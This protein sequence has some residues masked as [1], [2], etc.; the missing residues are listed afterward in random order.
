[1]DASEVVRFLV[2]KH[3]LDLRDESPFLLPRKRWEYLPRLFRDLGYT[4]GAEIGVEEG[5]FSKHLL[6][7]VPGLHLSCI[8]PWLSYGYYT[9]T[10]YSQQR[11]D[12]K[13]EIARANLAGLNCDIIQAMSAEA[14]E[15]FADNSLDFVFIDGN[16]DFEYVYQDIN[17]WSRKVRPGGIVSG[18]DY[19][20]S[21]VP[22][23]CLV[24]SAVDAWT[25][26]EIIHPWFVCV[27]SHRPAWFY[28]RGA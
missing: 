22:G 4:V 8:D 14:V 19:F 7:L 17:L 28:V 15:T 26:E 9:E 5:E 13:R 21:T 12:E 11:M 20:N 27:G 16:H 3:D 18:D 23:R 1:M 25:V 10:K 6:K 24:R 2:D